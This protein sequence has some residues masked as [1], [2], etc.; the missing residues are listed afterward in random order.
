M[1]IPPALEAAIREGKTG[2]LLGAGAS[3]EARGSGGDRPPTGRELA[4]LLAK[5]FLG[6]RYKDYPLA[7]IAEYAIS[8]ADLFTVQSFISRMV[9]SFQPSE[10][11]LRLPDFTWWGLATTNFDRLIERAYQQSHSPAQFLRPFIENGDRIDEALRDP[12]SIALLKLHGC[13]S[14]AANAQCP[15]ILTPDQYVTHRQGRSRIFDQLRDWCY[16]HPIVF[17]GQGL[18]DTDLR[19]ILLEFASLESRPRFYLVLPDA[20]DIQARFWETKRV[21]LLRGTFGDFMRT[22]DAR[23]PRGFRPVAVLRRGDTIPAV[24]RVKQATPLSEHCLQFLTMDVEY[25]KAAHATD[26]VKPSEFYKGVSRGWSAIEQNLDV[27]RHLADT[28]LSD[29]F[30]REEALRS[31]EV[32]YVLM[33]G[34]AGAGKSVFL[35]RVAWAASKEYDCLCLFVKPGGKISPAALQEFIAAVDTRVY[36]FVDDV[37]ERTRELVEL[38]QKIGS[39]GRRLTIIMAERI[40]EW[41]V[42]CGDLS[43]LTSGEYELG[44]LTPREIDSLLD[45][46]ER[47][48]ALGTLAGA[49]I[50][51]RR[52]ALAE[53]AGRQLLVALHEATLGLPFEQIVEDEFQNLQPSEAQHIY[54]TVCVL[55]RLGVAVRAGIIA[56]VHGVAFEEFQQR[57]FKPLEFVVLSE[58]EPSVRDYVYRARH[59]HIAD[60]VFHRILR[61]QEDRYEK[62]VACLGALNVDYSTDRVAFRHMTRGRV[63]MELFPSHELALR[64]YRAARER[65]GEDAPLFHQMGIYEMNRPGGSMTEAGELLA[66][67]T[68]LAPWDPAIKHSLAEH[69]LKLAD[70]ARTPLEREKLRREAG[71]IAR[72]LRRS[73]GAH[74]FGHHTLVKIDLRRLEEKL[75]DSGAKR[76]DIEQLIREVEGNLT[77]GL[78]RLPGDPYLLSAEA[79]LAGLLRDSDRVFE[80]L[81]EAFKANPRNAFVAGRLAKLQRSRGDADGAMD[82]LKAALD[83]NPG[84]RRLHFAYARGLMDADR[85]TAGQ[86]AY[87]LKRSFTPGDANYDAQILYGRQLFIDGHVGESIAFFRACGTAKVGPEVREGLLYPLADSFEGTVTKI[88]ASYCFVER[89]GAAEWLFAHRSNTS[90]DVWNRL[91]VGTRVRFRVAFSLRGPRAYELRIGTG[92]EMGP[93][94]LRLTDMSTPR[95]SKA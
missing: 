24:E 93:E 42:S 54:L 26:A 65:L 50:E 25:V 76:G 35:R 17:I 48:R 10:G 19:T 73:Q 55:N 5:E 69:R 28:V 64:V 41:N 74:T 80:T 39:E 83:A 52:E 32:E 43:P 94:Q 33:K 67:A 15:F 84:D 95:M 62:Y 82:T 86:L 13:T 46:L 57:F 68:Q 34:H 85:A 58:M 79:E 20:D 38:A 51:A 7:Q 70:L 4:N 36:L 90:G 29:V 40:N 92:G 60:I 12:R 72:D 44:Y 87:H 89:D 49:S 27:R 71:S 14:R 91:V 77:E 37:A 22:I 8:E 31:G 6:G 78:Q 11:H 30:L 9:D 66:K 63:V 81:K 45:L 1:D 56:R 75:A 88:E 18:Q 16:E 21:S 61:R 47:H 23:V 2:L 3:A 59:P 53:R